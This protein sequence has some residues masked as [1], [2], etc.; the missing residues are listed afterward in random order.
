MGY[1]QNYYTLRSIFFNGIAPPAIHMHL[2][3][4]DVR[5]D[6]PIGDLS[7]SISN[8]DVAAK[9]AV[10]VDI[11]AEEKERFDI[12][13]RDLWTVKDE[14]ITKYYENGT[15]DTI[16]EGSTALDI[17]LRL[18]R[19]QEILDAIGLFFPAGVVYLLGRVRR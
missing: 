13:L 8:S 16:P 11:P 6:I 15:L 17:P 2:R 12:W 18:R 5:A 7:G 19:K 4:F 3:L 14:A 1:G 9:N 10:E